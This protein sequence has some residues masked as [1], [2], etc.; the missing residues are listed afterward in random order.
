MSAVPETDITK[1]LCALQYEKLPRIEERSHADNVVM[2]KLSNPTGD[3][4]RPG[5]RLALFFDGTWNEPPDHTN[6][7]R[8]MVFS[9]AAP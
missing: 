2:E 6:V 9:R 3:T 7:R 5:K 8:L 1:N 4:R